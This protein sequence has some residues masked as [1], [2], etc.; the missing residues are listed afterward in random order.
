MDRGGGSQA[1]PPAAER[2]AGLR[3]VGQSLKRAM[4]GEGG[5]PA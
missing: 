2:A 5:P 3:P 4:D 1:P